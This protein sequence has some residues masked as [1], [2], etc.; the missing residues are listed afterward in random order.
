MEISIVYLCGTS[1]EHKML[2]RL[3]HFSAMQI[4]GRWNYCLSG[5][6]VELQKKIEEN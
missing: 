3:Y 5:L 6:Q 2:F 1:G 4:T